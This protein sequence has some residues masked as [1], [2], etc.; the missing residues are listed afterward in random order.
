[1]A[2]ALN[3]LVDKQGIYVPAAQ[4]RTVLSVGSKPSSSPA[5]RAPVPLTGDR[6][7]RPDMPWQRDTWMPAF[8]SA[9]ADE[10]A[11]GAP[12]P[13]DVGI[14]TPP[15]RWISWPPRR[16]HRPPRSPPASAWR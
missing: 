1:M 9:L 10:A 6:V 3:S 11:P 2:A 8:L 7:P 14:P 4:S 15:P 13:A 5:A 12:W 16:Y